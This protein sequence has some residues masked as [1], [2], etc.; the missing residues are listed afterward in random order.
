MK[1][2]FDDSKHLHTLDGIALT[3]TSSVMDVIAKPLTWWASGLAVKEFGCVDPKVLTKIKGGKATK[4]ETAAHFSSLETKLSEIRVMNIDS[5]SELVD[6][7]YRAHTVKLADSAQ[8]GTDLHAVLENWIKFKMGKNAEPHFD[9]ETIEKIK[10]FTDWAESN[11]KEFVWSEANCYSERLFVGGIS[12]AGAILNDGTLAVIDFK[13]AKEA[14]KS[15]FC[16]AAGYA[17]EI[18]ENGLFS[19][20]GQHAKKIEQK[21][22]A[23]IVVPFGAKTVLP[24]IMRDVDEFKKAFEAAVVLY[25]LL[26]NHEE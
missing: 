6:K 10:P 9:A 23:L 16:Q 21:V 20:N 15:H 17:I 11:V 12:D 8:A 18:E 3:G 19:A 2:L 13:S 22:C 26:I 14:Y 7:A 4:K 24:V 1:Y 25:R 5:Y